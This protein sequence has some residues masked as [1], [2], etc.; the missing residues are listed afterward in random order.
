MLKHN[1][2]RTTAP[3]HSPRDASA[4]QGTLLLVC[5]FVMAMTTALLMAVLDTQT[6]QMSAVRNTGDYDKALYLAGAGVNHALA[7]LESDNTWRT[8]ISSTQFPTGSGNTYSA[9]AVDGTGGAVVVTGTGTA[10]TI[11]RKVQITMTFGG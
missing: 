6:L 5:L 11:T 2:T 1:P 8:G 3:A 7:M 10:G 4:R 9:M